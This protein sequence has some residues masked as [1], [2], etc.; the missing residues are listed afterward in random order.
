MRRFTVLIGLGAL[1]CGG[2]S[3]RSVTP[4]PQ[5]MQETVTQFLGAV[6][7]NNLAR[8]G[9]LWGTDK[10]PAAASMN[11]TELSQRLT[12]IQRYLTHTGFRVL[13]GPLAVPGNERMRTFRVELQRANCARVLPLD[14]I[15]TRAG[16][17]L[18]YDVHL[19]AAGNPAMACPPA[20]GT[21]P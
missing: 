13:E 8:M 7:A 14:L 10:G 5:S 2:G 17:W 19:E 12:V 9:Q 3:A 21:R 18:V 6:K 1:A 4:A 11:P 16:G 15:Q 20:G